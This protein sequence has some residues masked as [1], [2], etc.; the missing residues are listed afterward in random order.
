MGGATNVKPE[1]KAPLMH[2]R[3]GKVSQPTSE[4][5]ANLDALLKAVGLNATKVTIAA[6]MSPGVKVTLP[7]A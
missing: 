7:T 5:A 1:R 4:L 6:T 2:V 3:I